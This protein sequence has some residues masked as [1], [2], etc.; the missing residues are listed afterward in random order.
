MLM[1]GCLVVISVVCA[2]SGPLETERELFFWH[3]LRRNDAAP[4]DGLHDLSKCCVCSVR[5]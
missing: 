1:C 5:D 2:C 3:G 4:V